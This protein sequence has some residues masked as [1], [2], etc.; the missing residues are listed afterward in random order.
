MV[1]VQDLTHIRR[2]DVPSASPLSLF[3]PFAT[4]IALSIVLSLPVA[5]Q[6]R[7]S[8]PPVQDSIALARA[9]R[10]SALIARIE[11]ATGPDKVLHAEPLYIDLIRDL[12]ARKGEAE[13]NLGLGLTDRTNYDNIE[14]LVEYEWAPIDRLGL[15]IEVPVSLYSAFPGAT[16]VP[17]N[18]VESL[19]LGVQRTVYVSLERSTS[20]AVGY[21]HQFVLRDPAQLRPRDPFR[22]NVYNPF[23]VAAK[24]WGDNFHTLVYTGA[25]WQQR[26]GAGTAPTVFEWHSNVDYM[27]SG[28]RNFVG[29]EVN[30]YLQARDLEM[31]VRPS[32]RLAI[33][34][35]LLMGI[36]VGIPVSRDK[37][38]L[39]M[40]LRLIY[41]PRSHR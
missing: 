19:K 40:F 1:G 32:M 41:E 12:G 34:D 21:L 22:G 35:D 39:G 33:R 18:R 2:P 26:H 7:D 4:A 24:R 38:R 11:E 27:L 14:A 6:V 5:A 10:D 25:Q 20:F 29:L 30:K 23:V 36:A 16:D 31:T 3:R 13:W 9:A 28:T 8:T 15:E 17:A 37:E